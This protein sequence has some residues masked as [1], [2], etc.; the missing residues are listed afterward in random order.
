MSCV[1]QYYSNQHVYVCVRSKLVFSDTH[2]CTFHILRISLE[3][4]WLFLVL[5]SGCQ[6]A[7]KLNPYFS[8]LCPSPASGP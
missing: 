4:T 8:L 6:I 5:H 2:T 1:S 7:T 3:L